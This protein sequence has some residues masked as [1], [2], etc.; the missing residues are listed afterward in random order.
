MVKRLEEGASNW[1]LFG[2]LDKNVDVI[3]I[4]DVFQVLLVFLKLDGDVVTQLVL[5]E[6]TG[7]SK[8]LKVD[9]KHVSERNEFG[10][11]ALAQVK[12]R[13]VGWVQL[14]KSFAYYLTSRVKIVGP[15]GRKINTP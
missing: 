14:M 1:R 13:P 4:P 6:R 7:H 9:H 11:G 3:R 8:P 5:I 12:K 10:S 2:L 15:S